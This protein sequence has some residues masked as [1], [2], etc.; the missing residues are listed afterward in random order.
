MFL[1]DI[2]ANE[3]RGIIHHLSPCI[4]CLTL[5]RLSAKRAILRISR[6]EIGNEIDELFSHFY[7]CDGVPGSEWIPLPGNLIFLLLFSVQFFTFSCCDQNW[8]L[9]FVFKLSDSD[10]IIPDLNKQTQMRREE[11]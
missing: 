3:G 9:A 2:S 5:S 8:A 11:S 1:L 10:F 7:H 6:S 4:C